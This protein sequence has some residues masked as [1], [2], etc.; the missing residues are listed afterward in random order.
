MKIS[1][2][3]VSSAALALASATLVWCSAAATAPATQISLAAQ[4]A[5]ASAGQ[6]ALNPDHPERYVVKRGDTVFSI[7][8]RFD[9]A[10][11]DL[12]RWNNIPASNNLRPGN[13]LMVYDREG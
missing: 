5:A 9:V 6:M 7:A 13:T 3:S 4:Q 1:R 8:R 2:P 10:V 12:Q 11:N